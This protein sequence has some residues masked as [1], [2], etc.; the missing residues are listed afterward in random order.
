MHL[1]TSALS[2][3]KQSNGCE[4]ARV[5]AVIGPL[6]LKQGHKRDLLPIHNPDH[7]S[8]GGKFMGN[9]G[10]DREGNIFQIG[11]PGAANILPGWGPK[12]AGLN[13][14]N[15]VGM[16]VIARNNRDVTA[17]QIRASQEFIRSK[18]PGIPVFGHGEVNPGHKEADEGMAEVNAIR[19]E[20]EAAAAA[21]QT[22]AGLHGD[23]LRKH[24]GVG[25]R[26]FQKSADMPDLLGHAREAGLVGAPLRHTVEGSAHL[27]IEV[28]G[29]R[30]TEASRGF[31]NPE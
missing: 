16:E 6:N 30:G 25:Q 23:A 4:P 12:G 27:K 14:K 19:A 7:F 15:I 18:Y 20:R 26:G 17:A 24:F 3:D 1:S 13:N 2:R 22:S 11:K 21:G 31:K 10:M 9:R 5:S 28:N 8:S 29:P